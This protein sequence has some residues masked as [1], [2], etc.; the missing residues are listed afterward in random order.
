MTGF[1]YREFQDSEQQLSL[2]LKCYNNRYLDINVN[3]PSSLGSLEPRLREY[4]SARIERGKVELSIRYRRLQEDLSFSVDRGAIASYLGVLSEIN[5]AAG[6]Q[7]KVTLDHIL[8]MEDLVKARRVVDAEKVWTLADTLLGDAFEDFEGS[9]VR[10]GLLT[11]KSILEHLAVIRCA[12]ELF[13]TRSQDLERLIR[14]NLLKRFEQVLGDRID[15]DRVLAETAVLLVKF[16]IDEEVTRL[17]GHLGAF[18]AV[19]E[20][21]GAVGKK[22][23]FLCQELNR[24]IN[25]VG[26]K[27]T[28]YEINHRVVDAKDALEKIREQLRN[29]E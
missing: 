24:E 5:E 28:L 8:T 20:S 14:E 19:A 26:S 7:E 15:E 11:E 22:L 18:A 27:S 9:R 3:L 23:D 16:S 13:E 1:G 10:E 29:V 17:F 6:L 2:E 25:T 12:A 4:L 21:N